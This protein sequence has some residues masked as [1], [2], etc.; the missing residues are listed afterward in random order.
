MAIRTARVLIEAN[1]QGP[2]D[3]GQ[4]T[5]RA[6]AAPEELLVDA[7]ERARSRLSGRER[8][9][10]TV[11]GT[12]FT[13]AALLLV[14][15]APMERPFSASAAI[16]LA[17]AY[18][19]ASRIKFEL[20]TD[21][22]VPTQLAFV[23][24]LFLLPVPVV[25]LVVAGAHLL[26][27]LPDCVR[28]R[29]HPERLMISLGDA[30]YALGPALV[31]VLA[32]PSD[33]HL[34]DWPIFVVALAAQFAFDFGSKTAREW[35]ELHIPPRRQLADSGWIYAV[36]AL[37]SPIA[38]L[39]VLE[40]SEDRYLFLLLLPLI[41]LLGV[42]ARERHTRLEHGLELRNA[43]Y[44]TTVLL[45]DLIERDDEYT[46]LHSRTVVARTLAVATE[47]GLEAQ[48]RRRA[49]FAALLH[50]IGKIAIPNT[51]INKPGPLTSEEWNV[52]KVHTVE[53]QRMLERVGGLLAE[54][55]EIVRSTH[56]HWDGSGYPDGLSGDEIPIESR[57]VSCCDAFDAMT[58]DRPYRR[59]LPFEV[60]IRE[61]VENSGGQF[62]PQVA[63]ALLRVM[64]REFGTDR[65]GP[66]T[67]E[68]AGSEAP[69]APVET[70][71]SRA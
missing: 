40:I 38:L 58:T 69:G 45:A 11:A 66:P 47:L 32:G 27:D 30:W 21:Y 15:L 63:E 68:I 37:L 61:I 18:A 25:P 3:G 41:G 65:R 33:A 8:V 12:A 28:G 16:V 26:S 43:Y 23:P 48:Q 20:S 7:R 22:T 4:P 57:I 42:F 13:A 56:E 60:A 62:D 67:A 49:E 17:V 64:E 35:Y 14:V 54:V 71:G 53:G 34:S 10:E 5:V 50:D 6:Y 59:A 39:A 70:A 19:L 51:I 55:G 44:G 2:P 36:D 1:N 9:G 24:M 29:R 46:G 31:L 52:V